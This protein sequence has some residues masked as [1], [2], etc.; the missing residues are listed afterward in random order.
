MRWYNDSV[1]TVNDQAEIHFYS[2]TGGF[3]TSASNQMNTNG[4]GIFM[5][6]DQVPPI[7]ATPQNFPNNADTPGT[8]QFNTIAE[9]ASSYKIR[10]APDR[11]QGTD[12]HWA[13]TSFS[14]NFT[15]GADTLN[16]PTGTV[17]G[18]VGTWSAPVPEPSTYILGAIGVTAIG[19]IDARRRRA[20]KT[21]HTA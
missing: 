20:R 14:G 2:N 15:V 4:T 16:F 9:A 7:P 5:D 10:L 12:P 3:A 11:M 13:M 21:A 18:I 1:Q 17:I 6:D 8:M 19:V